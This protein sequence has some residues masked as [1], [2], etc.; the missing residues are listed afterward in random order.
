[1]VPA[2]L[3]KA[4][5]A[6]KRCAA[7]NATFLLGEIE[8]L[9]MPDNSVDVITSN[10]VINL[11]ED[12]ASVC[13]EAFRVLRPGGRVAVS[14]VVRTQELPQRLKNEQSLAC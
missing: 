3:N 2:M 14:D 12:K 1:M 4:R 11:S 8:H 6:A 7:T 13:Q 9:P 10:C 5:A